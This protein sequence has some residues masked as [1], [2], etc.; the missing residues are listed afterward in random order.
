LRASAR[1]ESTL[2]A[3]PT[4]SGPLSRASSWRGSAHELRSSKTMESKRPLAHATSGM[5][6]GWGE[7]CKAFVPSISEGEHTKASCET[8]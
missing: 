7:G 8:Q 5:G 1:A 2:T 3:I 6:E 4:L